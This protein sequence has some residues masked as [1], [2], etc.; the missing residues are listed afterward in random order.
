MGVWAPLVPYARARVGIDDGLLGLLL[1]CLG[2]GS[3]TSMFFSG[4]LAGRYGCRRII[5][6]S[7]VGLICILPFMS[8]LTTFSGMMFSLFLFGAFLGLTDVTMNIQAAMVEQASAKPIMSGFHGF[9]SIGGIVGSAGGTLLLNFGLSPLHTI[10]VTNGFI[11]LLLAVSARE[12]VRFGTHDEESQTKQ[13]FNPNSVLVLIAMMCLVS[14][15]AEGAVLDWSGVFLT[16]NSGLALQ[17]AGWGYALFGMTMAL[18][19]FIGDAVVLRLG[20]TK[21]LML[22]GIFASCGYLLTV[23]FP[24]WTLSLLGFALIGIGT[25]NIVPILITLAGKETVMPV[26]M[27]IAMVTTIGYI[28]ILAGPAVIGLIAN[29][30][31][32]YTS[33]SLLAVMLLIITFGGIRLNE[34]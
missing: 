3:M 25:A 8:S 29:M 12:L 32:L 33:F 7:V 14:F 1:L 11:L 22:S 27:S 31:D 20:R 13:K 6:L 26:N 34:K 17:N 24:H 30:T 2:I 16:Q 19:R 5:I 4:V 21:T 28:G 9:F 15:L 18:M 23:M 10:Y